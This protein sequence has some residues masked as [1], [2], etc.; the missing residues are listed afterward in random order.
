MERSPKRHLDFLDPLRGFAI[1][2]VFLYHALGAAYGMDQLSW[3]TWT[4]DFNVSG[5][6]LLL[7]PATLGWMGVAVFFVISGFCI[8]L[9]FSRQPDWSMF[10]QRRFYRIYPPYLLVLLFFAVIYPLSRLHF[11]NGYDFAQII[12]HAFLIHNL[13]YRSHFGLN[14]SFWSVAVE[15][16][17]YALYPVVLALAGRL[18]W[19]RTMILLA[20]IEIGLRVVESLL[21]AFYQASLPRCLNGSPLFYWFSWSS[22]VYLAE[23]YLKGEAIHLPRFTISVLS[24]AVLACYFLRPISSLTFPLVSLLTAA[25]II[26]LLQRGDAPLPIPAILNRHLQKVGFWSYS[27]YL[28]NQ[29]LL[30]GIPLM[31]AW[32]LPNTAIHPFLLFLIC[33]SSWWLIVPLSRLFYLYAELPSIALGKQRGAVKASTE[34][35]VRV[36]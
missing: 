32:I 20:A 11:N 16:Q 30:A 27:L 3:G 2:L 35:A 4:R 33:V 8:H 14:P 18:G 29:P 28:L 24:V 17:L 7:F 25:V 34:S 1:L 9:S 31:V 23:R 6:F 5:S 12:S 19:K 22:G 21:G 36:G 26:K 10:V 13:D 15:V